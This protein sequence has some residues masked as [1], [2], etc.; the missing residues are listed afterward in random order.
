[1]PLERG[2][3]NRAMQKICM[4]RQP[5]QTAHLVPTCANP[6]Y[7]VVRVGW[8]FPLNLRIGL[9]SGFIYHKYLKNK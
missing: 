8:I 3:I 2:M 5:I 1:M 9:D 7:E 4:T 6:L